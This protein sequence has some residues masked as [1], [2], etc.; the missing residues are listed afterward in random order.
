MGLKIVRTGPKKQPITP[1]PDTTPKYGLQDAGY[2]ALF[3]AR[4][5]RKPTGT[6]RPDA[7][8][9]NLNIL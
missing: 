5:N 1:I 8:G 4:E 3:K 9:S 6:M 7:S 2:E